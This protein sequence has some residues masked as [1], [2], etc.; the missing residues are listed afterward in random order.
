M[1]EHPRGS[2]RCS[3]RMVAQRAE[4]PVCLA[5]SIDT[6]ELDEAVWRDVC[7]LLR[8]PQRLEKEYERRLDKNTDASPTRQSLAARIAQVKRGIAR[9]IDVYREGLLEKEEFEPQIRSSKERLAR[10]EA[11]EKTQAREEDQRAE[12]RVV[13]GQLDDF[14][15]RM[16]EGLEKTDWSTRREIIR[17]LVK[18]IE[19]SDSEVRIVYRVN[20]DPFAE[21]PTGGILQH[22]RRRGESLI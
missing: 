22:C 2:Y 3:G 1:P 5:K 6:A 21:A 4:N 11:D 13:I 20:T 17:A 9:L 15:S 7:Q 14:T 10:L 16:S 18:Q 19:V 12:L 8:Q